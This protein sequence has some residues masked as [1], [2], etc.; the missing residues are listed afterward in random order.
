MAIPL[1]NDGTAWVPVIWT[2]MVT[3]WK[4]AMQHPAMLPVITGL[5]LVMSFIL[6]SPLLFL[7]GLVQGVV[8]F[9]RERS[10]E[11]S[12][13]YMS[14]AL[15]TDWQPPSM[16]WAGATR[17]LCFMGAILYRLTLRVLYCV[18]AAVGSGMAT[19]SWFILREADGWRWQ[20]LQIEGPPLGPVLLAA[21][22]S[23]LVL[24]GGT[25]L[26]LHRPLIR[27]A[28]RGVN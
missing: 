21:S 16:D 26:C 1:T 23:I 2:R 19:L 27:P 24:M 9:Q 3:T 6:E 7:V 15:R 8:L 10:A 22:V 14:T 11:S 4:A 5:L 28:A 20:T 13:Q 18:G 12:S 25:W 17:Q